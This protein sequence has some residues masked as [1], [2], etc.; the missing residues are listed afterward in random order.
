MRRYAKQRI[1]SYPDGGKAALVSPAAGK[2]LRL[3]GVYPTNR[4]GGN[5]DMGVLK[6]FQDAAWLIGTVNPAY[7]DQT[8]AVQ[9]G[10]TTSLISSVNGEGLAALSQK[11]F[12]LLGLSV[13]QADGGGAT[14]VYEYFDGSSFVAMPMLAT[15]SLSSTGDKLFLFAPP[16]DWAV[17]GIAAYPNHYAIR[18][19]ATTAGATAVQADDAWVGELLAFQGDVPHNGVL[20]Y[21]PPSDFSELLE[22]FEELM[23]YFSV[24]SA[25]NLVTVRYYQEG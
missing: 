25:N 13:T 7:T 23:P 12:H 20:G 1:F 21:V 9:G 22:N 16:A 2:Q 17:G 6:K 10:T 8:A 24:P 15:P 19:R 18:I 11:P 3:Y 5:Q 4:S 14:Y